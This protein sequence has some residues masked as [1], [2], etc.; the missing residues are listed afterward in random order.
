MVDDL[1]R[2]VGIA[3][4]DRKVQNLRGT[5][6]PKPLVFPKLEKLGAVKVP[7]RIADVALEL[8]ATV[9][10]AVR[11]PPKVKLPLLLTVV[12]TVKVF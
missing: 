10:S 12:V 7:P 8:L 6:V 4:S 11:L 2:V 9:P 1:V 5:I 3:A